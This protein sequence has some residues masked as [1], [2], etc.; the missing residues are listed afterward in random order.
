MVANKAQVSTGDAPSRRWLSTT[1]TARLL[2]VSTGTVQHMVEDGRL[3]AWKTEGGHRRVSPESIRQWLEQQQQANAVKIFVFCQNDAKASQWQ[4]G[5]Q[6]SGIRLQMRRFR[7]CLDLAMCLGAEQPQ[8]LIIELDPF[9][10]SQERA[11][12]ASLE[13]HSNCRPPH[14]LISA[15]EHYPRPTNSHFLWYFP[16][17]DV[18]L[19]GYLQ[20]V[21]QELSW[22]HRVSPFKGE[23]GLN[24][25]D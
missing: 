5:V 18:L 19:M 3:R 20:A 22:N 1:Q 15:H 6:L 10:D 23:G 14:V 17:T 25:S 24:D 11:L 16:L 8:V 4:Q 7:Q 21:H 2:G 13:L 12:L 9:G